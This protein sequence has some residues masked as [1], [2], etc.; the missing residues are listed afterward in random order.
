MDQDNNQK[1]EPVQDI[2]GDAETEIR[3]L[4]N[5]HIQHEDDVISEEEFRNLKVG[6]SSQEEVEAEE[7]LQNNESDN[8]KSAKNS[9]N[10]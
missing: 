7:D 9:E 5:R 10:K 8:N 1:T 2:T 6:V 3:R 4:V